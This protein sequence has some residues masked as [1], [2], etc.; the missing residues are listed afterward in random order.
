MMMSPR[1][2]VGF[3]FNV[4]CCFFTIFSGETSASTTR[5][6]SMVISETIGAPDGY[7]RPLFAVNGWS[8]GPALYLSPGDRVIA[9]VYN[10]LTTG[11]GT[12]IHWHGILQRGSNNMDGVPLVTQSPIMPGTSFTYN[13]L[14]ESPGTF[15]YHSHIAEQ[16]VEGLRA[17]MIV[18][19]PLELPTYSDVALLI[20]D[21]YHGNKSYLLEK[22]LTP[23]ANGVE[24]VPFAAAINGV[25]QNYTCIASSNCKYTAVLADSFSASCGT[26][27]TYAEI[28]AAQSASGGRLTRLRVIAGTAFA[29]MNITVDAHSFWVT[30]LDSEPV[31]PLKTS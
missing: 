13:F 11:E 9:N 17:P 4:G 10:N 27:T 24:P 2:A 31:E 16:Y 30:A 15:W 23:A 6:F 28:L 8:P 3:I 21:H 22:Y 25:G 19:D 1:I 26:Y 29:I 20:S 12:S 5:T 14:V 18:Q 7:A